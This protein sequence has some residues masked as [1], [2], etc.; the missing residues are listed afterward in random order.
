MQVNYIANIDVDTLIDPEAA[1]WANAPGQVLNMEGTPAA[2]QPTEV[3]RET[4]ANKKI[5]AVSKVTMQGLHN[6]RHIAFRLQWDAPNHN[7]DHGDNSV[8]P[9]GAA[10]AFPLSE[11]APVMTMGTPGAPINVWFWRAND[12]GEGLQLSAEGLGTSDITDRSSV[13]TKALWRDGKWSVV[14]SREMQVIANN[15]I[16]LKAGEPSRFAVAVWDG[17]NGERGGIKSYSGGVWL[18]MTLTVGV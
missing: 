7:A 15:S 18:D 17:S 11:Q 5:G 16:Q 14:I 10:I 3:I 12:Q 4:W 8:F 2:L 6:A 1:A 13:K 9:D